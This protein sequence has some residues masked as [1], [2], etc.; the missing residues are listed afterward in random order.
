MKPLLLLIICFF[1]FDLLWSQNKDRVEIQG[2]IFAEDNDVENISIYNSSSNKGTITDQNGEFSLQVLLN[3]VIEISALQ[4]TP[5]TVTITEDIIAS[6]QIKVYL[7]EHFHEL[8]AVLLSSGLTGNLIAD[9]HDAEALPELN[10]DMGN[11][12][13][14]NFFDDNAFNNQ[15]VKHE[16]NKVM[17]KGGLYNGVNLGAVFDLISNNLFK[18]KKKNHDKNKRV[19]H[20]KPIEILDVYSHATL[21]DI[22]NIP[23]SKVELFV[24]FIEAKGVKDDLYK[25]E[26]EV[27]LIDFLVNQ[28]KTFLK[29]NNIKD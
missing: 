29:L 3:D 10:F 26:N 5:V 16:L 27:Y 24:A 19:K 17:N 9:I 11:L 7:S 8:K 13:A 2:F 22:C 12:D 1:S 21:S 28:S 15:I 18:L 14:L 6:K 4:F 20:E 25:P 23:V